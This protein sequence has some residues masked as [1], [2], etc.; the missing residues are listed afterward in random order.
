MVNSRNV[1][2]PSVVEVETWTLRDDVDPVAHEDAIREWFAWVRERQPE[3]FAEWKSVR[4]YREL[5]RERRTP[6][7]R[8][9]MLF[10]FRSLAAR[11]AYKERRRN[12]DGPYAA[13]R[14]VDPYRF[15]DHDSVT[16]EFWEPREEQ[17]WMEFEVNAVDPTT[18]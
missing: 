8:F 6:T 16:L 9:I 13:Y 3:L 14:E 12:W 15:F 17:L 1:E 11:D 10:E 2:E 18:S 5:D 4:Y 7:G